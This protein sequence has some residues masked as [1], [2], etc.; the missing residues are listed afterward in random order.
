MLDLLTN[1]Q[2]EMNTGPTWVPIWVNVMGAILML[3]IPFS[4]VRVEARW[5]LLGV[6]AGG[7]S[8]I[9]LYS[10]FGFVRL[11][12]LGHVVFWTPT[13][14]YLLSRRNDWRVKETLAG[15]WIVLAAATIAF[16]LVFDFSDVARWLLGDRS[17]QERPES[18][19]TKK[20]QPQGRAFSNFQ[21]NADY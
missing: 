20:A 11:L 15:K 6:L 13:L 12:G 19:D 4:F 7:V 21:F 5:A 1:F 16:S 18:P 2:L 8:T 9:A 10:Q 3:S 17:T 14:I